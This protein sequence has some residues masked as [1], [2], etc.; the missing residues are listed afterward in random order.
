MIALPVCQGSATKYKAHSNA[1]RDSRDSTGRKKLYF[2][3]NLVQRNSQSGGGRHKEDQSA[4]SYTL[5][6]T[7]IEGDE[8]SGLT[9]IAVPWTAENV[10]DS[11]V[12][13]SRTG[14][15]QMANTDDNCEKAR[16][17]SEIALGGKNDDIVEQIIALPPANLASRIEDSVEALD[18]L[19]E[20]LEAINEVAQ[21]KGVLSPEAGKATVQGTKASS[22]ADGAPKRAGS[23]SGTS[24]SR[25]GSSMLRTKTIEAKG[26]VRKSN[27]TSST[28]DEEK[29]ASKVPP[30]RASI[31]RP[32]S[33]LPPKPPAR[34]SK[35][36]TVPTFELPGEAVARRL[37]EQ[38]EARLSM[39]AIPEQA[40][41]AGPP[42]R[43]R[44]S[45]PLT[46]PT[47]ELPGEAISRQKR[48]DREEKL[49]KQEQDERDKRQF[50]ARPNRSSMAPS[51]LPRETIASRARTNKGAL[52]ENSARAASSTVSKRHSIA[53]TPA[54]G[55]APS[56]GESSQTVS[57]APSRGRNSV[58]GSPLITQ[59]SRAT[60]ASTGSVH[61]S[62][63]KRS[64]MSAEELQQQKLR[65][66]G[67]YVRDNSFTV[68]RERERREREAAAKHAR[69]EAAER[70]RQLSREWAEK[71]RL[72]KLAA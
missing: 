29:A 18:E 54:N 8:D 40:S 21:L 28:K 19:E 5:I 72:K 3:C 60:S 34:S 43:P 14:S 42:A 13:G 49:R 20:Q 24:A 17:T 67:I 4:D 26:P 68:D 52:A 10:T 39:Q 22:S 41:V 33:L 27:G 37:K 45:K 31:A 23:A 56:T 58:I 25:P 71:Q 51:T 36:L 1:P 12:N 57:Q 15:Q 7:R 38:R 64:T 53:I 9:E 55:P 65:G 63:G 11:E 48:L 50:K 35:P 6:A 70:S 44:S 32:T 46:R 30:K 66:K 62:V 16:R 2:G 47:F 59:V 61:G 69:Q